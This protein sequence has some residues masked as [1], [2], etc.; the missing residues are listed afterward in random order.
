MSDFSSF[1][2]FPSSRSIADECL[3]VVR[4]FLHRY[5]SDQ[6]R[7]PRPTDRSTP[8]RHTH[9]GYDRNDQNDRRGTATGAFV[10]SVVYVVTPRRARP[11]CVD[12]RSGGM[13]PRASQL[14]APRSRKISEV[15]TMPRDERWRE[16]ARLLAIGALRACVTPT[17]AQDAPCVPAPRT[18]R[19]TPFRDSPCS[20]RA[21]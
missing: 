16:V 10:V 1:R 3:H 13:T 5:Q 21:A 15:A 9:A 2:S 6:E 20:L 11:R 19:R 7:S 4:G 18:R 8:D 14:R 17:V 12:R